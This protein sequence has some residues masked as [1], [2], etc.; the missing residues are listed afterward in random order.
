MRGAET[1]GKIKGP[2]RQWPSSQ[3]ARGVGAAR[4]L[5]AGVLP[6]NAKPDGIGVSR[7]PSSMRCATLRWRRCHGFT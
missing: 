2:A 3:S 7:V 4:R 6:E 1:E 5:A